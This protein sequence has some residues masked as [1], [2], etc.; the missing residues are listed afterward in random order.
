MTF[1]IFDLGAP[2]LLLILA[3]LLVLFGGKKLPQLSRSLG[4]SVKEIKKGASEA[5]RL[6][7]EMKSQVDQTKASFAGEKDAPEK[8]DENV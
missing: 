4:E 2:E 6:K 8:G 7:Q 3:I 1:G 5:G